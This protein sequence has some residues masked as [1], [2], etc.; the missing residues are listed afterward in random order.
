MESGN[1]V[2]ETREVSAGRRLPSHPMAAVVGL[3]MAAGLLGLGLPRFMAAI[4][5]ADASNTV[6]SAHTGG[7]VPDAQLKAADVALA[8]AGLWVEEG[9]A[10]SERG[11]LLLH[12]AWEMPRGPER[13]ALLVE[14]EAMTAAGLARAPSQPG[15]WLRLA[16]LRN[17]RGDTAGAVQALRLSFLAGGFVPSLMKTRLEFALPLLP[18]MDVEMRSLLQRQVRLA[19]VVE[20]DY[21]AGLGARPELAVLVREALESVSEEEA[22][23]YLQHR[24]PRP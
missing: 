15:V 23:A 3:I 13:M 20:P 9:E 19:W 17:L 21:V 1:P 18:A 12:R 22:A 6:W 8:G 7:V 5:A 4:L 2:A 11:Y 24:K 14:A 10:T 16:F